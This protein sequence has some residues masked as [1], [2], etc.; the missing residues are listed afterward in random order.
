MSKLRQLIGRFKLQRRGG[1]QVVGWSMTPEEAVSFIRMRGKTVLTFFGYSGMGYEDE[2]G[3]LQIVQDILSQY[4]PPKTL[5]NIGATEVGVGKAYALAKSLG[6]ETSGI[7]STEAL[8]YPDGISAAV[9]HVCFIKDKQYGGKLPNSDELSPTSRAMVDSSD[10]LVAIGGND[11]S[12]D[13]LLEG[14][15]LGKPV[16]YFSADMNHERMIRR[17]KRMGKSMPESFS[18]SCN[19]EFGEQN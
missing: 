18:G 3:M 11:I 19:E 17:A 5:I 16:Q 1:N 13:E 7:V 12:R 9:D 2:E 15:K 10:I 4:L 6:F 8:K 14:K